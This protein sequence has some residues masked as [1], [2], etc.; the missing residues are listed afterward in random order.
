MK[1]KEESAVFG[2]GCFWCTEAVF[3]RLKGVSSVM[4]GYAGGKTANPTYPQVCSEITG[5]AEV[6]RVE[7]D[8]ARITY[9]DL[10]T[11][12]FATHDPTSLNRQGADAGTQYRST[13]LY[14][15]EEQRRQAE[16]FI[17]ELNRALPPQR[18]IVT[19]VVPLT[20]FYPAEPYHREYY[21]NNRWAPYCQV[22]IDPKLTKLYKGFQKL[23]KTNMIEPD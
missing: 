2:G 18:Q 17:K 22:V 1:D 19:E 8:P 16:E 14:T 9:H 3:E 12:F 13:I 23:L 20:E 6:V 15:T 21:R 11:V 10:L 4:P 7:Y 5:H